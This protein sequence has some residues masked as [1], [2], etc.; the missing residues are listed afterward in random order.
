[1]I[2]KV[3]NVGEFEL[4][5]GNKQREINAYACFKEKKYNT[6]IIIFGFVGDNKVYY[7]NAHVKKDKIVIMKLNQDKSELVNTFI[8]D[9]LKDDL[10]D[11]EITKLDNTNMVEII[12][13][14]DLDINTDKLKLLDDKTIPKPE[15]KN[16]E[17]KVSNHKLVIFIILGLI[18]LIAV[19]YI[20]VNRENIF[21]SK[22]DY[23]CITSYNHKE[24]DVKVTETRNINFI[25]NK[26]NIMDIEVDYLFNDKSDYLTFKRNKKEFSY[27]LYEDGSYKYL[28]DEATLK[29][30]YN[31][32]KENNLNNNNKLKDVIN[33][34]E[35]KGYKCNLIEKE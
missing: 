16:E 13:Y 5:F 32:Y 4:K 17:E 30:F 21:K 23:E 33:I 1:M 10:K 26:I 31:N 34:L 15:I 22:K 12:S 20:F 6:T 11:Y 28:D 24:L 9:L 18:L 27:S 14:N 25:N 19:S 3:I 35:S 7:G 29:M 8:D 2:G